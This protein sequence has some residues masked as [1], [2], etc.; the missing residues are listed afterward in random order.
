LLS[1]WSNVKFV[2]ATYEKPLVGEDEITS[3]GVGEDSERITVGDGDVGV[4]VGVD[5]EVGV[6]G[7]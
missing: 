2:G 3:V 5:V 6:T 1:T 7:V 4:F